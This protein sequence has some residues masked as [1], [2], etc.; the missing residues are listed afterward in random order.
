MIR[1][2]A[3]WQNYE[4]DYQLRRLFAWNKSAPT[5]QILMKLLMRLFRKSVDKIQVSLKSY[6]NNGYL[7]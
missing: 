1:F 7:T 3:R 4:N 2:Q 6:K 5:G